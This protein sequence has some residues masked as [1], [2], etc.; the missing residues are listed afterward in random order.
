VA[1]CGGYKAVG[2]DGTISETD[3]FDQETGEQIC[4]GTASYNLDTTVTSLMTLTSDGKGG[5]NVVGT[6]NMVQSDFLCTD[7][8][9]PW[10]CSG[11]VDASGT[12]TLTCTCQT[13]MTVTG[14]FE[15]NTYSGGWSFSA[16]STDF[17]GNGYTDVAAGNFLLNTVAAQVSPANRAVNFRLRPQSRLRR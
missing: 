5:C 4:G 1:A 15:G 11:N 9:G 12:M 3:T 6:L 10:N 2:W 8:T 17:D 7:W 16:G 14:T 13:A